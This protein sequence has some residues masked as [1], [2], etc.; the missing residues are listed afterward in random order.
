MINRNKKINRDT[1]IAYYPASTLPPPDLMEP[2]PTDRKKG[3][4]IAAKAETPEEA[5]IRRKNGGAIPE[6]Y[7]PSYRNSK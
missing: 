2:Y 1:K 3:L 5:L 6:E 7:I 4:E